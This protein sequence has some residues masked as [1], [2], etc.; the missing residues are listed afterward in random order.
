MTELLP[1]KDSLELGLS[2]ARANPSDAEG[3]TEGMALTLKMLSQA[4]EKFGVTE[5][6]P[7]GEAF[8]PDYHQAISMQ[9]TEGVEPGTVLTVVQKGYLLNDRLVRPA[10]VVVAK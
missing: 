6:A 8:D 1:V 10:M 5:L 3:V 7:E 4:T 2:A 9:E